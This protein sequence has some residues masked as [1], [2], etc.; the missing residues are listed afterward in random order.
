MGEREPF[1]KKAK[2][3]AKKGE[4]K[5]KEQ[6][7]WAK[8]ESCRLFEVI[9]IYHLPS[10]GGKTGQ[11]W[12]LVCRTV[13]LTQPVPVR[14]HYSPASRTDAPDRTEKSCRTMNPFLQQKAP[15]APTRRF[16]SQ[17]C[18]LSKDSPI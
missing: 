6:K 16:N 8:R 12:H 9:A 15:A 17:L 5:T 10:H 2:K 11:R 18:I 4:K 13:I 14:G 3:L 1:G 7:A